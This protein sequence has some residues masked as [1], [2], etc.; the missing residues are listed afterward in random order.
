MSRFHLLLLDE[1]RNQQ[2]QQQAQ[3][4]KTQRG[5]AKLRL[6]LFKESLKIQEV[7]GAEQK[8]R[9]KQVLSP[10]RPH[11][12]QAPAPEWAAGPQ[13]GQRL[14]PPQSP[15]HLGTGEMP[16][17]QGGDAAFA[18][19]GPGTEPLHSSWPRAE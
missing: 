13:P 12:R 18:A 6:A 16:G 1:L 10:S 19:V 15:R 5:D 9:T 14:P 3:L 4:L 2:V 7:T 11:S 17:G 8:D